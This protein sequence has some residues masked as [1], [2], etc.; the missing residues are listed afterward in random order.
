MGE[1]R[2]MHGPGI[3]V[4]SLSVPAVDDKYGNTWQYHSRSDRHSKLA[5]WGIL[6]D[7][8]QLSDVLRKQ[9]ER[10]EIGFGINHEMRDFRQ[11]RKKDL[12]LVLCTPGSGSVKKKPKT[13]QGLMAQYGVVL[14]AAEKK[15]LAKLPPLVEAPVG[16]VRLALEAKAAMTAHIR[17][18]PRFFDELN[19][20]HLTIH[21]ASDSAIA[22]GFTMINAAKTFLSSDMHKWD[23]AKNPGSPTEHRQPHDT[24]RTIGKVKELPRRT[25]MN[26]QG[27]DAIGIVVVDCTND[28]SPV[29]LVSKA[30]APQK[31]DI[32]HYESMIH[33]AAQMYDTRYG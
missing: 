5:C 18:L 29:K 19:S 28:G 32:F 2:P 16:A 11:N 10:G 4:R 13:L 12:D 21:G 8:L 15:I 26:E 23:L 7:L 22:V 30:P 9:V 27:Y 33:R 1:N 24:E 25:Q 3:L 14:S 20:S 17:A 31:G 6:F